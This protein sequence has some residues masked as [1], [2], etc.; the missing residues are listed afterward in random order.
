MEKSNISPQKN[1]ALDYLGLIQQVFENKKRLGLFAAI[2]ALLG[3]LIIFTTAKEYEASTM[4]V[5]ESESNSLGALGQF[6]ALAGFAGINMNQMQNNQIALTSDIFP[7]VIGSRDFLKEI[8]SREFVFE[9][10]AGEKLTLGQ[11]YVE[12]KPGNIVKKT[13]SFVINLPAVVLGWFSSPDPL[14]VNPSE[15]VEGEPE[16]LNISGED[17]FAISEIKKRIVLE[18]KG[19]IIR[20]SVSMPEPVIAAQVNNMVLESLIDYVTDYKTEKQRINLKFIEERV[21]ESEKKFEEAQMR[22]ASFRDSNQGIVSQRLR[23]REEQLQ[24]EFNIAYNV[25]NTL[26]QEYEQTAIQLKKE[27]PVFTVLEKAAVPL[28]PSKPNKPLILIFSIF[29]GLFVG[30]LINVYKVL[31]ASL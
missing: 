25:Y 2:G 9:S 28:G 19:K 1:P 26:K 15:V 4:V 8:S 30:F 31:I 22:L 20:L 13:L 6:G 12:E 7:D 18:E 16:L 29:V 21:E 5:L 11:Y 10:R 27:T 3:L 17:L 14:P 23:T 24:F